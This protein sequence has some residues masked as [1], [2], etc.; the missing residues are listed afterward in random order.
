MERGRAPQLV[1]LSVL[2]LQLVACAR[3]KVTYIEQDNVIWVKDFAEEEPADP[4]T[5]LNADRVNGWGKVS[6]D[7]QTDTTTVDGS[8][9]IGDDVTL[10]TFFQV[11]RSGHEGETL[12]V[13]GDV[14]VRPPRESMKRSDGRLSI[15]NRLRLGHPED[16]AIRTALKIACDNRR[17]YGVRIGFREG[18][19]WICRGA[20]HVHNS[21]I[22]AAVQD[23]AHMLRPW[24][25][26]GSDVRLINA[27][28]SWI[29]GTMAYGVQGHNSTIEETTFEHGGVALRNGRQIAR[30]CVFRSLE[31]AVAEGGCLHATLI[32]CRFE[33]NGRN[34]TLG[35]H[36]G[37]AVTLIDCHLGPQRDPIRLVR[38]RIDPKDAARRRVPVYPAFT[39]WR[40]L[41]VKVV[42]P[43]GHP[44][45]DALVSIDCAEFPEAVQ[46]GLALTDQSGRTPA[47]TEDGATLIMTRKL[48]ATDDPEQPAES[49][50]RHS[51]CVRRTGYAEAA[52]D[53]PTTGGVP[54]P[55][56]V[57]L[58]RSTR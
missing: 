54:E 43:G 35:G 36:S 49:T 2:V 5:V 23:R 37:H 7:G 52:A 44:V 56:V 47:A 34:W 28:V 48:Q 10:G 57:V 55:F 46:H 40:T 26:Y 51:V 41:V 15:V 8:L 45:P 30:S 4:T 31:T 20:L 11:G 53:L 38:N 3:G 27:K 1:G 25:W 22:T 9:W 12:V 42:D 50:Y 29:D 19:E 17:Q 13:K 24:G 16:A 21:T 39:E 33:N 18:N 6:H 14:W 32:N 58:R